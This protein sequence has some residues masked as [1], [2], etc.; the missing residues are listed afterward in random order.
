MSKIFTNQKLFV[1]RKL[2]KHVCN[3]RFCC[4]R[5][6]P[7]FLHLVWSFIFLWIVREKQ[8]LRYLVEFL[9]TRSFHAR[10][11]WGSWLIRIWLRVCW[12]SWCLRLSWTRNWTRRFL[13]TLWTHKVWW[14]GCHWRP[15]GDSLSWWSHRKWLVRWQMLYW[16]IWRWGSRRS[17]L[18]CA[19][20]RSAF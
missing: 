10:R 9:G 1:C 8:L 5:P 20:S 13:W 11:S 16:W 4:F 7:T 19:W 17:W 18:R 3:R 12:W 14:T 2:W 6:W 15:L